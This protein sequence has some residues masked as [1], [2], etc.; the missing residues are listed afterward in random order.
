MAI[1]T[2]IRNKETQDS[3]NGSSNEEDWV[4]AMAKKTDHLEEHLEMTLRGPGDSVS[5][6]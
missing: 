5:H 3:R 1:Y 6:Q 4:Q 2:N